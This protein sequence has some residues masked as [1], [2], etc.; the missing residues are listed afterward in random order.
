MTTKIFNNGEL[1]EEFK[2][3]LHNTYSP[4]FHKT[5]FV[6]SYKNLYNNQLRT[7]KGLLIA[8][9]I[10]IALTILMMVGCDLR[11][12]ALITEINTLKGQVDTGLSMTVEYADYSTK[13]ETE[14]ASCSAKLPKKKVNT[15][16]VSYYSKDGCIGCNPQLRTAS[17]DILD[18]TKQT[19]ALPL[20]M[21]GKIKLGTMVK[22]TNLDNGL[23]TMAKFNDYGS[24]EKY[25]R[26][27]DLSVATCEA[28]NCKTDKS[29]VAIEWDESLL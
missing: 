14:L 10:S 24:F 7:N 28:I 23:S 29:T 17:G 2:N 8:L 19:L 11:V 27:G 13:L 6:P 22:V 25:N 12:K 5:H 4:K 1:V 15:G 16:K 9:S 20:S 21:R 3:D 26:V 18:D